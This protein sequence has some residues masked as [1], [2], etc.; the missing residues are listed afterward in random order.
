MAFRVQKNAQNKWK[1]STFLCGCISFNPL[2]PAQ[3]VTHIRVN[4]MPSPLRYEFSFNDKASRNYINLPLISTT[5]TH[6]RHQYYNH[7]W[8]K[9]PILINKSPLIP[10]VCLRTS[11]FLALMMDLRL[12]PYPWWSSD[13]LHNAQGAQLTS[14]GEEGQSLHVSPTVC[15]P[16]N[17]CVLKSIIHLHHPCN[18]NQKCITCFITVFIHPKTSQSMWIWFTEIN[19][20][21][22]KVRILNNKE[23]QP[24]Y[25]PIMWCYS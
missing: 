4:N 7:H 19:G 3:N 21:D 10:T 22:F 2:C 9:I 14:E 25:E 1:E 11:A 12:V 16:C 13:G 23:K 8:E 18:S 15:S 6:L 17:S 20:A 24:G 5:H